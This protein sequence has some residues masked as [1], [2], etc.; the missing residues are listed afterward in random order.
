VKPLL[1]YNDAGWFSDQRKPSIAM[2]GVCFKKDFSVKGLRPPQ[3]ALR[4]LDRKIL[5]K[6]FAAIAIDGVV[7]RAA[8]TIR[9]ARPAAPL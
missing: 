2:A 6:L 8:I 1:C 3:A 9:S 4:A 7:R 5:L